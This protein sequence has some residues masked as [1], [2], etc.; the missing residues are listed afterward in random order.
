MPYLS[1]RERIT[2]I[3]QELWPLRPS[4]IA[5][6]IDASLMTTRTTMARMK[7]RGELERSSY[8]H[9]RLPGGARVMVAGDLG[10]AEPLPVAMTAADIGI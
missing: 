3:P 5:G 9:W 2:M 6:E 1:V 7:Q 4:E 8:G 10:L